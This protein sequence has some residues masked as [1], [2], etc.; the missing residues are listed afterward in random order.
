MDVNKLI[1]DSPWD[2]FGWPSDEEQRLRALFTEKVGPL[3]LPAVVDAI[4]LDM[5]H[6]SP[7]THPEKAIYGI[8][9]TA[10]VAAANLFVV[11]D[12]IA[13]YHK[14]GRRYRLPLLPREIMGIFRYPYN[15]FQDLNMNA[16]S[17]TIKALNKKHKRGLVIDGIR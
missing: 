9:N 13:Q 10:Q 16:Q 14:L 3:R 12:F 5:S 17:K 1:A 7:L 11:G 8:G 15:L 6:D 4:L 2:Y